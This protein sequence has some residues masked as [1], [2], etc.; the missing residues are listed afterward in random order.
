MLAIKTFS[1]LYPRIITHRTGTRHLALDTGSEYSGRFGLQLARMLL[2]YPM[3]K[4]EG[5][6]NAIFDGKHVA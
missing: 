6:A 3:K 2:V 5:A 1:L 4:Q